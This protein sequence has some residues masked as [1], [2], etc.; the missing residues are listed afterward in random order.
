MFFVDGFNFYHS[1]IENRGFR[2]YL[3]LNY[4]ALAKRKISGQYK[5]AGVWYFSAL[6]TWRPDSFKRHKLF[7]DALKTRAAKLY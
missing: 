3:W 6:A 2:K 1:L 4:I 7:I 5:L